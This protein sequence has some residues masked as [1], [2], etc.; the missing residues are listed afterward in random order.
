MIANAENEFTEA[1]KQRSTLE[2]FKKDLGSFS[3][4]YEFMSQIVDYNDPDLEK[5][6]L[7][8]RTLRPFLLEQAAEEDEIDLSN[9]GMSHYRLS[10]LRQQDIQLKADH[11][12][13]I[14]PG[15]DL[16]TAKAKDKVEDFL[17][18]ILSRVNDLFITDNLTEK[19]MLNYVHSVADKIAEN[20][21]VMTQIN[22]N[23]R[24]QAMLGDFGKAMDDAIIGCHEAHQ[25]QMLQLMTDPIK[26]QLFVNLIYDV[27]AARSQAVLSQ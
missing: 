3:R 4:F 22:H 9:V 1:K 13:Q 5:L 17:S 18:Q 6:S 12:E 25:D 19:D 8:A 2:I 11:G 7:Y 21:T 10:K 14:Q 27:L 15:N 23:S 16:G 20:S 26:M 24:E